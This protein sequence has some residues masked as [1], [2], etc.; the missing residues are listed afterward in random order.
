M[1]HRNRILLG[2]ALITGLVAPAGAFSG[3]TA[4]ASP[5]HAMPTPYTC[6]GGDFQTGTFV[7]IPSGTYANITVQG[8]CQPAPNAVINVLGNV[9][10][11]A[12]G[13]FDAQSFPSTITAS[14]IGS[15]TTRRGSSIRASLR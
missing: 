5:P 2:V 4:M 14:S 10:V 3:G 9:N 15:V 6:T 7:P 13:A 8:A 12:H 1:K 11:A